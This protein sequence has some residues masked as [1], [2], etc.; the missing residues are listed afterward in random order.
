MCGFERKGARMK[1]D[2][3]LLGTAVLILL[4]SGVAG[5][6]TWFVHPD[7]ALNSI[8]AGLDFC[9]SDDTV[10]VAVGTYY[11][12]LIWPN[13][14]G[15]NLIGESGADTTI[16]D[17]GGIGSAVTINTGVDS[18]TIIKAFTIQNGFAYGGGGIWCLNSSP[19]IIGNT[20]TKNTADYGGGIGC[21]YA[22]PTITRNIIINNTAN[23][24][25][26]IECYYASPII[27]GNTITENTANE[28]GSGLFCLGSSPTIDSCTVSGNNGDG[29]YCA[30][31]S[32]PV[33]NYNNITDNTGY[34][35][36]NGGPG[37]TV[38]AEHNWW[39]SPDGPG[40]VGSGSGDEVSEWVDYDPWLTQSVGVT[41][42]LSSTSHVRLMLFQNYPN[43]FTH[44]TT[45]AYELPVDDDVRLKIYN[46][47]GQVIRILVDTREGKGYHKVGWNGQDHSG[48][49]VADGI[50]FYGIETGNYTVIRKMVVLR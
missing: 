16:I 41:E 26:G 20:I 47:N 10:L 18:T 14:Q 35:L 13:T 6:M 5:G 37:I 21:S 2:I 9:S 50:Y 32:R 43:P 8:Q 31:G 19:T 15:I 28:K 3:V 1:R 45:I 36:Q 46:L 4:V 12:N 7:S 40:G 25:G 33:V 30:S 22:S 34:G 24:G 27:T 11:E 29:V 42:I 44:S 49:R 38:D 17:G 39:G 48:K 23:Y